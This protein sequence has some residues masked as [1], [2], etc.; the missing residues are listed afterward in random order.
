MRAIKFLRNW[1]FTKLQYD[2]LTAL[3]DAAMLASLAPVAP[4]FALFSAIVVFS[5]EGV[6][7]RYED[8][9]VNAMRGSMTEYIKSAKR[10][11]TSVR[12]AMRVNSAMITG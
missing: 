8:F 2:W 12:T 3:R 1:C 4:V 10:I 11:P 5:L 7:V 6:M 9:L